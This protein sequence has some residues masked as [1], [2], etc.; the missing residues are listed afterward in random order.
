M[1][2]RVISFALYQPLFIV[3]GLI[4]FVGAGLIAFKNLPVDPNRDLIPVSLLA[5]NPS[6]L[7][8]NASLPVQSL[9]ELIAYARSNPNRM[10]AKRKAAS[11]PK[12]NRL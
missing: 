10:L 5:L 6:V 9:P 4:L 7:I 11:E 2:K 3:F 8:V 12:R 1:I